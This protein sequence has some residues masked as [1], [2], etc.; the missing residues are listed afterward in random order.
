MIYKFPLIIPSKHTTLFWR[1]YN[2]HNV[3][4]T[5][6]G[7][8]NNVVCVLGNSWL[9]ITFNYALCTVFCKGGSRHKNW[10]MARVLSFLIRYF[11]NYYTLHRSDLAAL[12]AP[13]DPRL[14]WITRILL[15]EPFFS[16]VPL[17]CRFM[18]EKEIQN[19]IFEH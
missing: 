14:F 2:V 15:V 9:F 5:S 11:C 19:V 16:F 4:T 3:K 8:Q 10:C 12:A 18:L 1:L 6:Y 17:S 7:R 13:L